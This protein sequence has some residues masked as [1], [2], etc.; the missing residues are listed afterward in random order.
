MRLKMPAI[1]PSSE[2]SGKICY[3]QESNTKNIEE[4][5]CRYFKKIT[6]NIIKDADIF[7]QTKFWP[8]T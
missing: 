7:T 1:T 2:I 5:N 6:V 8:H 4:K 3:W